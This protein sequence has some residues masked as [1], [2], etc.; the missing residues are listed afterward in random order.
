MYRK[1]DWNDEGRRWPHRDHSRFVAAA[2]FDWH[3]QSFGDGPT[4]LLIHGAGA[5][6]HS[7]AALAPILAE[8][9][10]VIAFDLPGHGFTQTP[11][12][13]SLRLPQMAEQVGALLAALDVRPDAV[14]GHSAGAAIAVRMALSGYC[15]PQ[16]I[17]TLNGAFK[18]FDGPAAHLFPAAARMLV[19]NPIAIRMLSAG[20]SDPG[21]VRRMLE[22]TGSR[23][24]PETLDRYT[25]LFSA[26]GHAS[27][28]LTMMAQ[29]DL[30]SLIDEIGDLRTDLTLIVG[31]NDTAVPPRVSKA[32]QGRLP[33]SRYLALPGLGHL[34]HEEDP[35]QI[36]ALIQGA[37]ESVNRAD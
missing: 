4:I 32:V 36:A 10:R 20:A 13:R 1:P 31:E 7:Y 2:G 3:V 6:T 30:E 21:R 9:F 33:S 27:A 19:L 28:V 11:P 26:S 15:R 37:L 25:A 5:A 14:V 8:R 16:A 34:A 35:A 18:P 12:L 17:V 29:W 24:D 22:G 23:V